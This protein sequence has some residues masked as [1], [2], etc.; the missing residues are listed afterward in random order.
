[1]FSFIRKWFISTYHSVF[2]R[3]L[4]LQVYGWFSHQLSP[5]MGD[6]LHLAS[7][8][9]WSGVVFVIA[10]LVLQ[11][12]SRL[13]RCLLPGYYTFL[14]NFK[15]ELIIFWVKILRQFSVFIQKISIFLSKSNVFCAIKN[16][17]CFSLASFLIMGSQK[18]GLW[19]QQTTE[20]TSLLA[21]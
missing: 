17:I 2:Q 21:H 5:E 11:D 6:L 9:K 14:R 4:H 8:F 19:L 3:K 20:E 15:A 13:L 1:M 12:Q 7:I 18:K 16:L 10:V